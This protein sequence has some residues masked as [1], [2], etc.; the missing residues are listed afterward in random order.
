MTETN[1]DDES[2]SRV[3][4]GAM[5]DIPSKEENVKSTLVIPDE[6]GRSGVEVLLTLHDKFDIE[7]FSY[8]GRE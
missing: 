4:M 5:V 3:R 2:I 6:N 1:R 8:N 7:Q